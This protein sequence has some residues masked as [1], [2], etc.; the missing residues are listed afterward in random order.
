MWQNRETYP[1]ESLQVQLQDGLAFLKQKDILIEFKEG[2]QV[3]LRNNLTVNNL[4]A[5]QLWP[6]P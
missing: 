1:E 6:S 4:N 3:L 2:I 5:A